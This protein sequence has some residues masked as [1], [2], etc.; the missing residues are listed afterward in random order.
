MTRRYKLTPQAEQDL[1]DIW[2]YTAN[3]WSVEQAMHYVDKLESAFC[4]IAD[5]PKM[6]RQRFEFVP[7]MRFHPSQQHLI[8]YT[9]IDETRILIVRILHK[10]MDI[11]AQFLEQ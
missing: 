1:E 4:L 9:A 2:R 6:N 11:D 7:P 5:H 8:A 3:Q 10:N